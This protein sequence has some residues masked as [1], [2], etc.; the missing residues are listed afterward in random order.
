MLSKNLLAL[1]FQSMDHNQNYILKYS[2][3]IYQ[4]V[5]HPIDA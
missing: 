3:W 2:V 1:L 4:S 5:G